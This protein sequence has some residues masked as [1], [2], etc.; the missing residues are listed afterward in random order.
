[1]W[2]TNTLSLSPLQ[3]LKSI[4]DPLEVLSIH[5][6]WEM[7]TRSP[8]ESPE[9]ESDSGSDDGSI[10][11]ISS[12]SPT[13]QYL[14]G[15]MPVDWG[16]TETF[17]RLADNFLGLQFAPS[18]THAGARAIATTT[19]QARSSRA[20]TYHQDV[21]NRRRPNQKCH[22]PRGH[23]AP[24]SYATANKTLVGWCPQDTGLQDGV[25]NASGPKVRDQ[26][27]EAFQPDQT[28]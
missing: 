2:E 4:S 15:E 17:A 9:Y 7:H 28:T 14:S 11:P 26:K 23:A 10:S 8:L 24:Q 16:A 1:M 20:P 25:S 19:P 6:P 5:D 3:A 21:R 18:Q 12:H 27:I 22:A 13:E